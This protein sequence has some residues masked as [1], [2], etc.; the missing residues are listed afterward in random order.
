MLTSVPTPESRL[1]QHYEDRHDVYEEFG[2]GL[3]ADLAREALSGGGSVLD[4][5]CASGGLLRI[6]GDRASYRAGLELSPSAAEAARRHADEIVC[7][8]VDSDPPPSFARSSFDL[9]ICADVIEHVV[10][11]VEALRRAAGWCAPGGS[12]L[13]SVPNIGYVSARWRIAR[14]RFGYDDEGGIF[15][16]GHLHFFT[17][18]LLEQTVT[19]AG[20]TMVSLQ[21][22]VPGVR[23]WLPA[24]NRLPLRVRRRVEQGWQRA[25][26][27]RPGL[28][29][30]QL[31]CV[32]RPGNPA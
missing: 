7:G 9:V 16:S 14:G 2:T 15:D 21:P 1:V 17:P 3:V 22:V 5:G 6:L 20:L 25:G 29:G 4:I 11:P 13:V 19:R 27:R 28:L 30:F 26:R 10:D 12:V 32:A 23:N 24:V 8:A 31:V 18:D